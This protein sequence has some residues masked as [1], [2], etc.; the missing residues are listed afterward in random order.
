MEKYFLMN[1]N[2]PIICF[3]VKENPLGEKIIIRNIELSEKE[4]PDIPVLRKAIHDDTLSEWLGSWLESRNYAKHKDHL[5]RWLKEWGIDNT[6]GFI[7]LTHGLS[8][9]DTL[10]VKNT[11]SHLQW[12]NIN[13]YN[14]PFSDIAEK[15]AFDTGLNGLQFSSTSPELTSEGT[16]PKCWKRDG[17]NIFLYK[18]G[19][20]GAINV[21][22]EPYSEY[23][24]SE[25]VKQITSHTVLSYGLEMFK[26]RLCSKCKLFTS[27]TEGFIPFYKYLSINQKYTIGEII[28]ICS[29]YG[30]E[31]EAKEMFFTDSIIMNQDRHLGNFGFIVDNKTFKIKR[32]APFYDYNGSLLCNALITDLKDFKKYENEYLVGHKLGGTFAEVGKALYSDEISKNIPS[33]IKIPLHKKFNLP[34]ERLNLISGILQDNIKEI[35]GKNINFYLS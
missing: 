17:N 26:G 8:L 4:I 27:E 12:E 14:N 3:S 28:K 35:T 30:F 21:G 13:F 22:L 7:E 33:S 16:F 6:Q 5:K 31:N 34:E 2:I 11:V 32:F 23:I 1:G 25:I 18:T 29:K 24:S 15:T 9:N 19:L 20:T 10:W